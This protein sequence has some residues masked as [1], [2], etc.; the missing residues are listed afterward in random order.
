M[1]VPDRSMLI[2]DNERKAAAERLRVAHSEGRLTVSEYDSRLGRVYEARTYGDVDVL[3]A[4][5]PIPQQCCS[6]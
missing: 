5:L 2:S 4:D 1:T 6:R 3:F